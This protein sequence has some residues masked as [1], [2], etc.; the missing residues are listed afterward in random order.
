MHKL[1][2]GLVAALL[3]VGCGGDDSDEKAPDED[4][5][6]EEEGL[7]GDAGGDAFL[8]QFD[9][10]EEAEVDGQAVR[11]DEAG[12]TLYAGDCDLAR[13]ATAAGGPFEG[14]AYICP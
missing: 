9:G 11:I 1:S 3:L 14:W 4:L 6:L 10:L 13:S 7:E 12:E 2:A 5:E 8:E